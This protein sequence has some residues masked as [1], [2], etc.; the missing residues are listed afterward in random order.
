MAEHLRPRERILY[1]MKR[2]PVDR[3]PCDI[4][5]T[6]EVMNSL[7]AYFGASSV[8]EVYESLGVDKIL[9]LEAT[10]TRKVQKEGPLITT[11]WGNKVQFVE[12][13]SGGYEETVYYPLEG[14][15]DILTI[16]NYD[17][18]RA[19]DFD[20]ETLRKSCIEGNRYIRMLS[21]VSIFE[22][23][24]KLKPMDQALMD[25]YINQDFAHAIIKRLLDFQKSYILQAAMTCG[26]E[27]EIVY[28]SDDMG[29]QYRPLMSLSVWE[30]YFKAPYQELIDLIHSL[31]MYT[32]YHSDGA[33]YEVLASMVEMGVDIIN[34]IQYVCPGMEREK[35]KKELGNKVIFHGAVENQKVLPF[36]SPEEVAAE[37]RENIR[38]LGAGGGYIC[39][40]CH[41]IQAGTPIENI[42]A[43]FR[44]VNEG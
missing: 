8:F 16:Q 24:C 26:R 5:Y 10:N 4:W 44:T 43:L 23:Y 19:D 28:L 14:V 29:M 42:L 37:V 38:I 27:L 25:L 22:I 41:N 17:W 34:P 32:F 40:P 35:L 6:G 2:L 30:E 18:P 36:G 3:T 11:Q 9:F 13:A 20:Y 21:F 12:N 7:L 1:T 33:A 39:A 31:G 15:E